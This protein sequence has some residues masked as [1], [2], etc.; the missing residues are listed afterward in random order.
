M[1]PYNPK[2]GNKIIDLP[3]L[4]MQTEVHKF[5][6]VAFPG[7]CRSLKLLGGLEA[8]ALKFCPQNLLYLSD[9]I[10]SFNPISI[11]EGKGDVK[12]KQLYL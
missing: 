4:G 12:T 10:P 11:L 8:H 2:K 9:F 3:T 5:D 1:K 7:G 6:F